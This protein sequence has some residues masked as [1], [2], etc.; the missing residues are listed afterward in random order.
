M[1]DYVGSK[2]ERVHIG[3]GARNLGRWSLSVSVLVC[4]LFASTLAMAQGGDQQQPKSVAPLVD[5]AQP[6]SAKSKSAQPESGGLTDSTSG[7]AT[8]WKPDGARTVGERYG[9][10]PTAADGTPDSAGSA[11]TPGIS[12][13]EYFKVLGWLIAVVILAVGTIYGLKKLQSGT[14]KLTGATRA[15][16]VVARTGLTS[17]H[18]LVMVRVAERILIVGVSPDGVHRVSEFTDPKDVVQMS[19]G[20]S[21]Q[22]Q[23]EAQ[24]VDMAS[25]EAEE[26][27]K[28]VDVAPYRREIRQLKDL[29][30]SWKRGAST[31]VRR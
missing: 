22:E 29:I 20:E 21:F 7:P 19:R 17:K 4:L 31:G 5:A 27:A 23:L 14:A 12:L 8:A 30:G 25:A 18:Q 15:M 2:L 1:L 13:G 3:Q 10:T 6:S 11:T 26:E 16:E 28:T 9:R 24:Q